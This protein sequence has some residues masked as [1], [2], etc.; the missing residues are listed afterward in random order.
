MQPSS[1]HLIRLKP[2]HSAVISK[3][4]HIDPML[5]RRLADLGIHE[6]ASITVKRYCLWGGP[7]LLEYRGQLLSIRR[8][9]AARIE[10]SGS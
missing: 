2:G 5:R 4:I 1:E 7:V 9:E 8:R 10:V 6:G 3:L